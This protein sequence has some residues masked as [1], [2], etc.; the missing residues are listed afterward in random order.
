MKTIEQPLACHCEQSRGLKIYLELVSLLYVGFGLLAAKAF[1][2]HSQFVV[3]CVPERSDLIVCLS[4]LCTDLPLPAEGDQDPP[5][6]DGTYKF[7]LCICHVIERL[8]VF[9][10]HSCMRLSS[11]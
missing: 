11:F 8:E 5:L 6:N 9:L 2:G 10:V 3:T 7:C 1:L 4:A